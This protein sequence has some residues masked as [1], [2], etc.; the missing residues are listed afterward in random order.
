MPVCGLEAWR[1][2]RMLDTTLQMRSLCCWPRLAFT[3]RA[4]PLTRSV[5]YQR[6][7]V[8]AAFIN[9]VTLIVISL[10]IFWEAI[11]RLLHPQAVDDKLMFWVALLALVVNG[12]IM[13]ALNRG[14]KGNSMCERRSST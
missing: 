5:G 7:G 9:A 4:D 13:L 8:V 11:S 14:Q 12:G 6:A 3:S 10:Y 2:F 1:C